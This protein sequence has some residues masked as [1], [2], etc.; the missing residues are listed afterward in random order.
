MTEQCKID[1]KTKSPGLMKNNRSTSDP[2]QKFKYGTQPPHT[3]RKKFTHY[4]WGF[5]M[6][7]LAV[8]PGFYAEKSVK[9]AL[10]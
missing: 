8:T 10:H 1:V 7:F 5:L 6:L 9:D 2:N 3:E 4:L